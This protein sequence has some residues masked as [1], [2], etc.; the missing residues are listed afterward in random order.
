MTLTSPMHRIFARLPN[1][2]SATASYVEAPDLLEHD[3][4]VNTLKSVAIAVRTRSDDPNMTPPLFRANGN[5]STPP[6][7]AHTRVRGGSRYV[8]VARCSRIQNKQCNLRNLMVQ[9]CSCYRASFLAH[10][11]TLVIVVLG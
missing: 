1:A 3:T 2:V 8:Q 6:P 7:D 4:K 9:L 11:L 5:E 10:F